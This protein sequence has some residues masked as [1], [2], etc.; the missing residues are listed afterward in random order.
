MLIEWKEVRIGENC[1]MALLKLQTLT[2][3]IQA[4]AEE[5]IPCRKK[6]PAE[7]KDDNKDRFDQ[8]EYGRLILNTEIYSCAKRAC[9][10]LEAVRKSRIGHLQ[11]KGE[12]HKENMKACDGESAEGGVELIHGK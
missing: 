6:C 2:N 7:G 4:A 3:N 11:S 12:E 9:A 10:S 1:S 8:M 5:K